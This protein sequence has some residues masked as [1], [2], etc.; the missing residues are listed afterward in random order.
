MVTAA[1]VAVSGAVED[2]LSGRLASQLLVGAPARRPEH[3]V[4]RLLAVQAQD[5]RGARLSV[6]SRSSGLVASDV[7]HALS[8]ERSLVITWLNRGTLHL[9]AAED[10]WWLHALTTP[11]LL[12]GNERRLRQEGVSPA[13]AQRGMTVVIEAVT[14][15]GPQTRRQLRDRL[16]QEAVPTAGQALVHIL[17]A[18]SIHGHVVRGPMIG[19]EHA[20]VSVPDWLGPPPSPLDRDEAV[21]MLARRYLAGHGPAMA[22]DLAR[23]AG[24]PLGEARRGMDAIADEVVASPGGLRLAG[25]G[26]CAVA[27]PSPR[28]LGPFDPLLHGWASRE[29]FVGR[30]TGVVTTNGVF[31]PFALVDGRVVATWGL[32]AGVVSITLLEPTSAGAVGALVHD[33]ADVSRFLGLAHRPVVVARR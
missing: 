11:Q 27:L 32:R 22:E 3:V 15:Q 33:G 7:D 31:R 4:G 17:M 25:S 29:P 2:L 9:V 14:S 8:A 12:T 21:R 23:W 18:A 13:Q 20:Y 26:D 28:L 19:D 30:H 24:V 1:V 6:R 10:Y 16:D 5:P